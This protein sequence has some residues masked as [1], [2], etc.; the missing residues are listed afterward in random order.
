MTVEVQK[1]QLVWQV[2][3]RRWKYYFNIHLMCILI[4]RKVNL[5]CEYFYGKVVS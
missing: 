3:L 2:W 1:F 5:Y 4:D